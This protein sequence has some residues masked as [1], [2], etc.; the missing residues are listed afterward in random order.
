MKL[1]ILTVIISTFLLLQLTPIFALSESN[2]IDV[3]SNDW[4]Y[5]DVMEARQEGIITGVG[6]NKYAPNKEITY[7]EYLT[8]LTR[9]IGG[10]VE[11]E[12]RC[13]IHQ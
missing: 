3:K 9:V 12:V 4:F 11:N 2:F 6:D 13:R 10:K 8:V 1:K 5:N 7:G